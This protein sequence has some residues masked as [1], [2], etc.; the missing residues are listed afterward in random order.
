MFCKL[1]GSEISQEESHCNQCGRKLFFLGDTPY[2]GQVSFPVPDTVEMVYPN[3]PPR[4]YFLAVILSLMV[5][6]MG[7]MYVGQL[8]KGAALFIVALIV[9]VL[10][11]PYAYI[12][13]WGIGIIDTY[14]ISKKLHRKHP[15]R[16]WE[17]F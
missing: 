16:Q 3:D 15:V 7:Q 9:S 14:R 12:G 11:L 17:W 10:I 13:I 4:S 5:I 6:G 2:Y 1:C 8:A